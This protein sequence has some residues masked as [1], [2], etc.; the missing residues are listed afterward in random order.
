MGS[1]S[2]FEEL[3]DLF[4]PQRTHRAAPTPAASEGVATPP[5]STY[6]TP[7]MIARNGAI[8]G[9]AWNFSFQL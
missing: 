8:F 1:G 3:P 6:I 5:Y 7:T 9:I 4:L 2:D